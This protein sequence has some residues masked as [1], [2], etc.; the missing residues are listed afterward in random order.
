[1]LVVWKLDR[2]R[3]RLKPLLEVIEDRQHRG[4]DLQCLTGVP[5]DTPPP[6]GRFALHLFAAMA[7]YERALLQARVLAGI[8]A[9]RARGRKGGR[10]LKFSPAQHEQAQ[11]M[12]QGGMTVVK[13]AKT[14]QCSRHTIY[15]AL[16]QHA[17][18]D[19][20]AAD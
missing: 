1:V 9:A 6:H 18:M 8:A 20:E 10:R 4:I 14:L 13:I 2:L 7:E 11:A 19:A 17:T 12:H 15:A 16:A 5:C 3:R